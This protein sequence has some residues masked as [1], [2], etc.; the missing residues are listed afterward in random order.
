M[1]TKFKTAI[2]SALNNVS[3]YTSA[4]NQV[5][6][7]VVDAKKP[8]KFNYN[9]PSFLKLDCEEVT[10]SADH[11]TRPI[12]VPRNVNHLPGR[13]GYAE[14]INAGKSLLNED[15]AHA[16]IYN[17]LDFCHSS[18]D[19]E[20]IF[21]EKNSSTTIKDSNNMVLDDNSLGYYAIFD[22]HAGVG[23]SLMAVN[24]MHHHVLREVKKVIYGKKLQKSRESLN[25][26]NQVKS[27]HS[28]PDISNSISEEELIKGA[29]EQAFYKM[30]EQIKEER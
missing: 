12:I 18:A 19:Y 5:I 4:N 23:A 25:S 14:V 27:I 10:V 26:A 17:L 6:G 16:E 30:D 13:T 8:E 9:R 3:E 28:F 1:F 24:Y 2:T 21:L 22:G 11:T 15:Q 29:M 7:E 20:G